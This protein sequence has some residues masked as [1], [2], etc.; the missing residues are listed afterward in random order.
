MESSATLS[1]CAVLGSIPCVIYQPRGTLPNAAE[2]KGTSVKPH[3]ESQRQRRPRDSRRGPDHL[4]R[5]GVLASTSAISPKVSVYDRDRR[6][7]TLVG[8]AAMLG[9]ACR[10]HR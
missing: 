3:K 9:S 5:R 7:V 2:L 10:P 4:H 6:D 1:R 8:F